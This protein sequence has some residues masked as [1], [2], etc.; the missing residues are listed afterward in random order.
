MY[1]KL[2][3]SLY[4]N[5]S[6]K[7]SHTFLSQAIFIKMNDQVTSN[8]NNTLPMNF[9]KRKVLSIHFTFDFKYF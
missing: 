7:F 6:K 5:L 9:N 1:F 4:W 2:T 8:P 3:P